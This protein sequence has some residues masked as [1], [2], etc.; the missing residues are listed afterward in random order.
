VEPQ[1][2]L[3]ETAFRG[4][5]ERPCPQASFPISRF[6]EYFLVPELPKARKH[7]RKK[8][9]RTELRCGF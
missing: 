3:A 9:T 6:L 4:K 1:K 8:K 5:V 2:L 7:I